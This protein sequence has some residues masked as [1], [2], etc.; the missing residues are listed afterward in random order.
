MLAQV[1]HLPD[2]LTPWVYD[3]RWWKRSPSYS[4]DRNIVADVPLPKLVRCLRHIYDATTTSRL[5]LDGHWAHVAGLYSCAPWLASFGRMF[6]LAR[7]LHVLGYERATYYREQLQNP[8]T[9]WAARFEVFIESALLTLGCNPRRPE[10][11]NAK[12][13]IDRSKNQWEFSF[14]L[15]GQPYAI[16]CKTLSTGRFEGN[17]EHLRQR[18]ENYGL[19]YQQDGGAD[20]FLCL[21]P[22]L[23]D[24]LRHRKIQ[25]FYVAVL[26][27]FTEELTRTMSR[28]SRDGQPRR[29]GRFGWLTIVPNTEFCAWQTCLCSV[30][31]SS[32][33]RRLLRTYDDATKNFR[34]AEADRV[35]I[36]VAWAGT[37]Y[38]PP[39]E[40]ATFIERNIGRRCSEPEP[41]SSS[42][43]ASSGSMSEL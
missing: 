6:A 3:G 23:A 22:L 19:E 2:S 29:V 42:T 36:A 1:N 11:R 30:H 12:N 4:D 5:A 41:A 20:A 37:D 34:S 10:F 33:L 27:E 24:A 38:I 15:E 14:D 8:N 25:D 9:W 18:L 7:D 40:A 31:G 39:K 13:E 28:A 16:E 32:R 43:R 35:R 17:L 26:P 21:S